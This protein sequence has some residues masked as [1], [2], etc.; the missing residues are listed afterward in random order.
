MQQLLRFSATALLA[1]L[2]LPAQRQQAQQI[3]SAEVQPDGRIVFRVR[4]PKATEVSVTGDFLPRPL[5]MEKD[6]KG[7]WTA[8]SAP[9]EPAIYGY[10]FNV[11]GVRVADPASGQLQ[12]GVRGVSSLVEVPAAT[13]VFYDAKPVPHGAIRVHWYD[14]KTVGALRSFYTYT[15]PGYEKNQN[16][17]PVLYLLHGSGDTDAGWVSIGRANVILDNLIAEH[18][19]VPMVVVMPFGHAQPAVG[20]GPPPDGPT[21]RAL[22]ARD[23]IE[24]VMLLAE[25]EYRIDPRPEKRAIAGLSMGG[26]Q[27]LNIGLTH[28][29]LFHWIG[30]FSAGMRSPE[31]ADRTFTAAFADAA[32]T[33]KKLKLFWIGCGKQDGAFA[34]AK[35]IDEV[36][37]QHGIEHIFAPSEG[38][39]TWR[40]WRSYLNQ[41]APLLF[42]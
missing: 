42:R 21:D 9:L 27:S 18:K 12:A 13:P 3:R 19:A 10:A 7:L 8:T 22:F 36:L 25:A 32:A 35:N 39:H 28:L 11:N 37:T 41:M 31:E 16:K 4:A 17:Y 34:S 30:V 5:A 6:E 40:N 15:P 2:A 24:D 29:E 33:N 14:S 38:A 1:C 20:F 26:G 23:L